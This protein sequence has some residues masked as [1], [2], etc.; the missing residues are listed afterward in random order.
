MKTYCVENRK[1]TERGYTI[2]KKLKTLTQ[3]RL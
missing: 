3:K 1:Y 2:E